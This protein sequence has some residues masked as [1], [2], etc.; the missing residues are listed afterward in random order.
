V[1]LVHLTTVPQTLAFLRG[2]VR[3][4]ARRGF[5]VH[6]VSSPG[7]MLEKFCSQ[8]EIQGH[9]VEM[10][11]RITP[12]RDLSAMFA[13]WR[14]LR[15]VRPEIVHAHTP[16]AGLLGMVVSAV[17]GVPVRIFHLHGLPHLTAS[18]LR[19]SLLRWATRM[20]CL[21]SSRV[22]CVSASVRDAAICEGLVPE[23]KINVPAGGSVNGVDASGSFDP[24][25]I[26]A[27]SRDPL[28]TQLGIP[29]QSLVMGFVG[30]LV[31]EK[32]L[33]E[34]AD[35]W[36]SL[37]GEFPNLHWLIVGDAESHDPLPSGLLDQIR[38]DPRVYW[39]GWR[40]D[41][42]A[43][44]GAMD[45][46][47]LPSYREGLPVVALEAAAMA[48][49]VVATRVP[50]T[51]DAVQHGI[52]G[53]LVEPRNSHALAKAIRSYLTDPQLRATHGQAGRRRTLQEFVPESI[54]RAVE[55]EYVTL[56]R[57]EG[58]KCPAQSRAPVALPGWEESIL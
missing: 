8:E 57:R 24:E 28:R 18:G 38:G 30:R 31:C 19:R 21:V 29:A 23:W 16:K 41:L 39:T 46:L 2:Q 14:I 35:A 53:L 22:L 1:K 47:V 10:E 20:A 34:M 9:P 37:R 51:V 42:P 25:R 56:L 6:A 48:L 5:E 13:I 32:G 52:T 33:V 17:A 43:A 4:M 11:R 45:L 3:F 44:Y 26:A 50:G 15:R 58:L 55:H 12:L 49:P 36:A 7:S 27:D 54:W 40:D